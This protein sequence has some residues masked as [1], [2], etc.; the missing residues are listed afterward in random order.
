M[1]PSTLENAN[2]KG[3][4]SVWP[5]ISAESAPQEGELIK[6]KNDRFLLAEPGSDQISDENAM[7]IGSLDAAKVDHVVE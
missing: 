2:L 6:Q 1:F 7:T 3:L 4:L 5:Q